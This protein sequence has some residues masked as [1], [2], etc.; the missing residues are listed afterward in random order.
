VSNHLVNVPAKGIYV[1]EPSAHFGIYRPE[2]FWF[3]TAPAQTAAFTG[4]SP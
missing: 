1:W 3:D 4:G 2:T